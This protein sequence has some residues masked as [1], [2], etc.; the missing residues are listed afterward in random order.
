MDVKV[1][2]KVD[3]LKGMKYKDIAEKYEVSINT[4]KSWV[5]R[6]GW[7]A[8]KKRVK[9]KG[10]PQKKM[11][12]PFGNQNAKGNKG[13]DGA[14]VGNKR[15]EKHG[16]FSRIFP[17]DPETQAIIE[18][19]DLKSPL[20]ILWENIVIQ[21]TAIARAQKLMFVKD[22]EDLTEVLRREKEIHGAQSS[23]WE[24]EYELQFAWDKQATFLQAQS[25]A[26]ATLQGLITRYDEMLPGA[27]QRE[28]QRLRIE[29]LKA[30]VAKIT[31]DDD[32]GQDD[33]FMDALQGKTAEVW[34]DE[35]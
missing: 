27:L 23:G 21:Y 14:P 34:D 32:S 16:F 30:E 9:S 2:A 22:Q 8:E 4:V 25:R 11:G 12:A 7:A 26:I 3:Y 18:S 1:K 15:A 10:A 28:E 20:D 13:G 5:K 6:H 24:R 33:G 35:H 19:I 29:K 17:N 31:G